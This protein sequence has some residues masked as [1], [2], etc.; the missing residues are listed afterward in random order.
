MFSVGN[1]SADYNRYELFASHFY[2]PYIGESIDGFS[3]PEFQEISKFL[4]YEQ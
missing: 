3:N 1:L 2:L 4:N